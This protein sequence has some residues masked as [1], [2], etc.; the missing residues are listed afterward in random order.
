MQDMAHW[1]ARRRPQHQVFEGR[2]VRLEPLQPHHG[3]DLFQIASQPDEQEKFRYLPDYQPKSREEFEHFMHQSCASTDPLFF[4]AIDKE[5]GRVGGRLSLLRIDTRMGVI[6]V[7]HIYWGADMRGSRQATEAQFLLADYIFSKLG[8]RR[9]EWKCDNENTASKNAA[10]RLGFDYEG[11]FRQH[12]VTK[13]KNRDT[14]WFAMLDSDWVKLRPTYIAWL[15]PDNFDKAGRQKTR[16][17][18]L[19]LNLK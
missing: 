19:V 18:T 3:D 4:A 15:D 16:L 2:Y 11:L 5:S 8:Y 7:G 9:Y 17:S 6:E 1:V 14:A 10:L 13:G 12:R